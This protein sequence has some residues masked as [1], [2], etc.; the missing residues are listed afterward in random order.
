[1]EPEGKTPG[2]YSDWLA[3]ADKIGKMGKQREIEKISRIS[4]LAQKSV[5]LIS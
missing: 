4:E 3:K 1:M 5:S 2:D